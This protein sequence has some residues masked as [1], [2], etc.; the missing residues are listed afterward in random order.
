MYFSAGVVGS[1]TRAHTF[2][3][4]L[5]FQLQGLRAQGLGVYGFPG[6]KTCMLGLLRRWKIC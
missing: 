4:A 3:R 1:T 5:F 2:L 6:R